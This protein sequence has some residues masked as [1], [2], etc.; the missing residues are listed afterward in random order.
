MRHV[1]SSPKAP[2]AIGPYSQAIAV[3]N[4]QGILFVS[5]QIPLNP[6][7]GEMVQESI[8]AEVER[9]LQNV[10]AVVEEAG[11]TL[12][13]VVKSTVYLTDM[14]DFAAMNG[15][16]ARYFPTECPARAA[17]AVKALPKGARVEIEVVCAR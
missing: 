5:G 3:S 13:D 9:V 7:T 14:G 12:A 17:F 6:E 8:E 11:Y 4:P 10:K 2:K 16:Y 15:I 1:V